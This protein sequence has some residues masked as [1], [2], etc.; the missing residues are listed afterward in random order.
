MSDIHE[1]PMPERPDDG[2]PRGGRAQ[3]WVQ[4]EH[5]LIT[6]HQLTLLR[7]VRDK[8][9]EA[10]QHKFEAAR[11]TLDESPA[12]VDAAL[13]QADSVLLALRRA[14]HLVDHERQRAG[15]TKT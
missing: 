1:E 3:T 4:L 2:P 13:R 7:S 5:E 11:H 15:A 10:A 6:R 8:L 14:V 9:V 12:G